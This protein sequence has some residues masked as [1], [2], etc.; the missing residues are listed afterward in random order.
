MARRRLTDLIEHLLAKQDLSRIA[1]RVSADQELAE[2]A[3]RVARTT[4]RALLF[5]DV[6]GSRFPVAANLLGSARRIHAALDVESNA[7]LIARVGGLLKTRREGL[8]DRLRTTNEPAGFAPRG[9]RSGPCQQVVW[10]GA[11]I[12][13]AKLPLPR[14]WPRE[15]RAM[16]HSGVIHWRG[17]ERGQ[18]HL[19]TCPMA[20]LDRNH[21]GLCLDRMSP[22]AEHIRTSP[23]PAPI[24]VTLAADPALLLAALL[25]LPAVIDALTVAGAIGG[26]AYEIVK[27]RSHE[28][29]VPTESEFAIEGFVGRE[30]SSQRVAY[31]AEDGTY[32]TSVPVML[33]VS[34]V[35]HRANP[36][37]PCVV[38]G[39]PPHELCAVRSA[40]EALLLPLVQLLAP[41]VADYAFPNFGG[42][43]RCGVVAIE[44]THAA[45][46][47]QIAGL[48][49]GLSP[50]MRTRLLVLVDA[51]VDVH[52]DQA[53][54]R[55]IAARLDG[56]PDIFFQDASDAE[57]GPLSLMAIDATRAPAA[58]GAG[59]ADDLPAASDSIRA[60]VAA[61][62]QQLGL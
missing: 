2:I 56:R 55:A 50:W 14:S 7:E 40:L 21:L 53:V 51:D 49:W 4:N 5:A 26:E 13:L 32:Q 61:R 45:H 30:E 16:I 38:L 42:R 60:Q 57:G 44:K 31:A 22:L 1:P 10:L 23:A 25:P 46:P 18:S 11:D 28:V 3:N 36:V 29:E 24:A 27:C 39:P 6:T 43:Q 59:I 19:A 37:L 54:W 62:W 12:D 52:D 47:R 15:E 8:L 35:T 9:V 33:E 48:L 20:V 58:G 41:E 34:A 17:G